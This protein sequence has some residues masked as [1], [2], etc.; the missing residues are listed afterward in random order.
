MLKE[1]AHKSEIMFCPY[2]S[3]CLVTVALGE[4]HSLY[5]PERLAEEGLSTLKQNRKR[6]PRG[7][8][9]QAGKEALLTTAACSAL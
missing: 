4:L 9:W 1:Q 7:A 3:V 2:L 6:C 5:I 8:E